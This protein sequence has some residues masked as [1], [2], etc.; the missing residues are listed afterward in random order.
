MDTISQWKKELQV[1]QNAICT[2]VPVKEL[3]HGKRSLP[4]MPTIPNFEGSK[5][6]AMIL[7]GTCEQYKKLKFLCN[8][9]YFYVID[10]INYSGFS[11]ELAFVKHLVGQSTQISVEVMP[12]ESND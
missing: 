8:N 5:E 12:E 7:S 10:T 6:Y 2:P 3:C 1:V 9:F 4:V 11:D